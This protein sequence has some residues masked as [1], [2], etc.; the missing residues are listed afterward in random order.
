VMEVRRF[1][2]RNPVYC[3][4]TFG[5][6]FPIIAPSH[7]RTQRLHDLL[8][9]LGLDLGGMAGARLSRRLGIDISGETILR[10]LKRMAPARR[11]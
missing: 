5:E 7:R 8:W 11:S 3:R 4:R 2:C 9:Y 1:Q 6:T 10:T